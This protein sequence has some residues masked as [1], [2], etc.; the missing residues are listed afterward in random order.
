MDKKTDQAFQVIELM[1]PEQAQTIKNYIDSLE[2]RIQTLENNEIV[3]K[4]K[5]KAIE[6]RLEKFFVDMQIISR[7]M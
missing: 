2:T 7:P 5:T 4:T 1:T 6:D 3:N